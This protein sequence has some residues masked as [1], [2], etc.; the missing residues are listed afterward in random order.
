MPKQKASTKI[1]KK[2]KTG[3]FNFTL[4]SLVNFCGMLYG[5]IYAREQLGMAER[6]AYALAIVVL[7]FVNFILFRHIVYKSKQKAV[8]KQ[9][10][11][12]TFVTVGISILEFMTFS[13]IYDKV[14]DYRQ[15]VIVVTLCATFVRFV[16]FNYMVFK[17]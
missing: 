3:L 16:F 15:A 9:F 7:F 8:S 14:G 6:N 5:T 1:K 2:M 13:R 10:T 12:Y 11:G 17:R 4:L